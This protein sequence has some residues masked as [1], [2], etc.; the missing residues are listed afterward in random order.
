MGHRTPWLALGR[1]EM[2][3]IGAIVAIVTASNY[4]VRF[5]INDWLTWGAFSYPV[6][7]L[8]VDCINRVWGPAAAKRVILAG[9]VIGLPVSFLF[10]LSTPSEGQET[11]E[12]AAVALRIAS[13]SGLAFLV[14]QL[15]DVAVFNALRGRAWWIPPAG[16]SAVGSV[17]DT[18]LFFFA[19]FA[20]TGAPWFTWALGDLAAK[21]TM[22][23][24]LLPGYRWIVRRMLATPAAR[25]GA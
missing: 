19:A 14:A 10:N 2:A 6:T 11:A 18:F 25:A 17:G 4:L 3:G 22:I 15:A 23:A 5:A 12:V 9:F 8:V 1:H 16:S 20:F 13:A 7:F 24:A 21:G